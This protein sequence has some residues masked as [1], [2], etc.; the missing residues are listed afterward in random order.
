VGCS[1]SC[2]CEG[3]KNAFGRREGESNPYSRPFFSGKKRLQHQPAC[4]KIVVASMLS[5]SIYKLQKQ[6]P[7]LAIIVLIIGHI[8]IS[9]N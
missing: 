8:Q 1:I 9:T 5:Y 7:D 3:C 4:S 6:L 2:R